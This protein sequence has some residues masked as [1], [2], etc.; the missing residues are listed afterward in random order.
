MSEWQGES[1]SFPKRTG[2][3]LE[4][5][6]HYVTKEQDF[7]EKVIFSDESKFNVSGSAG[8]QRVQRK[9]KDEL[10]AKNTHPTV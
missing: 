9:S 6:K 5:A 4:V 2:D 8:R 10:K 1:R 7:C 3:R